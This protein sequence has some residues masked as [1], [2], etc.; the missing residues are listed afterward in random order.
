MP[1]DHAARPVGRPFARVGFGRVTGALLG[2]IVLGLIVGAALGFFLGT[3]LK[4]QPKWADASG[5]A[6]MRLPEQTAVGALPQTVSLPASTYDFG[7]VG[8]P[9]NPAVVDA[10]SIVKVEV[11]AQSGQVGVSLARPDGGE[12]VSREAT[13]TPQ[14]GKTAVYFRTAPGMGPV[15]VLL[16]S[17]DNTPA[18]A[19]VTITRVQTARQADVSP[20]EMAKINRVGVY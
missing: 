1:T 13:I 8:E 5:G 4:L 18:G 17:A 10:A 19:S 2:G 20:G 14:Q 11:Q 6:W 9:L 15:D 7:G 16:R 12:L 3:S